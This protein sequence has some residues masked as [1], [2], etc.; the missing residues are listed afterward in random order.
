M[1][2]YTIGLF[3]PNFHRENAKELAK[4]ERLLDKTEN[5]LKKK[6]DEKAFH[7]AEHFLQHM[8]KV[9]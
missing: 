9:K 8:Q 5:E 4:L 6:R 3:R 7:N 1:I 2:E